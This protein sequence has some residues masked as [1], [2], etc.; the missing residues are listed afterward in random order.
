MRRIGP[1][2]VVLVAVFVSFSA[3]GKRKSGKRKNLKPI[4]HPVILWSKTLSETED[5]EQKKIAA[6]KLSQ[7]SQPIYQDSVITTL[8]NC[9]KDP[10]EQIRVLCAKALGRAGNQSKK[11]A[12]RSVLLETF[13]SDPTLR[14]TLTRTF[15]TR[16]DDSKEVQAV[17][18]DALNKSEDAHETLA[19]LTYFYECG[20]GIRPDV[21]VA[22]FNKSNNERIKRWAIKVLAEHGSGENSVVE[23][24]ANCAES[25]DTPLALTCLSGLQNQSRKDSSRTWAALEKTIES[26]DPDMLVATID[27]LNVLPERV[28]SPMTKRLIEIIGDTDD[29]ELVDKAILALGVCGDQSQSLVET[30]QKLLMDPKQHEST[31]VHAALV[32]GKQA[33]LYAD[34]SR[35]AL[36]SCLKSSQSQSLK[37]ACQ[38]GSQELAVRSKNNGRLPASLNN[39]SKPK[40]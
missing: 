21:F 17:L 28:N 19:L 23:L 11:G 39:L 27:V 18:L 10:D 40:S 33:G 2:L 31:K 9:L 16:A 4:T 7:Y 15:T 8:L 6:F 3:H 25:Q 1:L 32:L 38:L 5:K 14:E 20:E 30:L 26:S 35:D 29:G 34:A 24:L 22:T 37:T 36:A 12:L 13:K